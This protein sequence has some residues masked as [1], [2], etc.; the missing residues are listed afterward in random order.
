MDP[1]THTITGWLAARAGLDRAAPYATATLLVAANIPELDVLQTLGGSAFYLAHHRTWSHSL[2][3]A[4]VLGAGVGLAF[5]KLAQRRGLPAPAKKLAA[6]GVLGAFTH[7]L[8]DWMTAGGAQ[9]LWPV[10]RAWLALDLLPQMDLWLLVALVL[11]VAL[12]SL[13][14]LITE[15]I[16]A[17]STR[18]GIRAGAWV[19]LAA[20]VVLTMGRAILHTE[21]TAQLEARLYEGRTP[22]RIGAFP[23]PL[24]PFRWVGVVETESTSEVVTLTLLG[25]A[26]ESEQTFYKP[27]A[28][29]VADAALATDEARIFLA[30]ARFPHATVTPRVDHGWRVE[31]RDLRAGTEARDSLATLRIELD[32]AGEVESAHLSLRF[33]LLLC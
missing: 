27:A 32:P 10:H 8:L 30:W 5:W 22:L 20:L 9:L 2:V 17:R 3:G 15:E 6:L 33:L 18:G 13:F 11:G 31:L 28:S 19:A 1:L 21:A 4:A 23:M 29:P 26:E 14:R 16:G 12:P 7:L 24:N 25:R